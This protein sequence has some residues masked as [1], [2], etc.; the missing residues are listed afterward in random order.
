M[1]LSLALSGNKNWTKLGCWDR[2]V[3]QRRKP[4]DLTVMLLCA[5]PLLGQGTLASHLVSGKKT[6]PKPQHVPPLARQVPE[7]RLG[8]R[9]QVS[10]SLSSAFQA[11]SA[12]PGSRSIPNSRDRFTKE[13]LQTPFSRHAGSASPKPPHPKKQQAGPAAPPCPPSRDSPPRAAQRRQRHTAARSAFLHIS[14][15]AAG[16]KASARKEKEIFFKNFK[17][18]VFLCWFFFFPLKTYDD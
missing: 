8:T 12:K 2:W 11:L 13:R 6:H 1:K 7:F 18:K 16:T 17:S 3:P 5:N 9:L 10:G 4:R 14:P 15:P